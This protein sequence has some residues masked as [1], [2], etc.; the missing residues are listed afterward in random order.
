M[1]APLSPAEGTAAVAVDVLVA[2]QAAAAAQIT[3]RTLVL[4]AVLWEAI[5]DHRDPEQLGRFASRAASAIHAAESTTGRL[6]EAYLRRILR[7]LG[8]NVPARRRLVTMPQSL[9]YGVPLEDVVLRP[10][11]TVRFLRSEDTPPD[12]AG[13]AGRARLETIGQTQVQLAQR[14]AARQI[15]SSLD[16]VRAFRRVIRPEL[17]EGG[18][19]GLCIAASDRVYSRGDLLPIHDKCKC[20]TLPIVGE[21]DPGQRLNDEDLRRLYAAAGGTAGAK[22]KQVRYRIEQHGELG[23]VL[24]PQ[25]RAFRTA[26]QAGDDVLLG[27]GARTTR[28]AGERA[29]AQRAQLTTLEASIASLEQRAARGEDV[30]APL[31][32]QRARVDELRRSVRGR[33]A[34]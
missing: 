19:C 18:T 29:A 21:R 4:L 34:A 20:A 6:T 5:T 27:T 15:F 10:A 22:L 2:Q 7:S 1:T 8:V 23:P 3:D 16:R 25:G 13:A 30:T 33:V 14:E 12:A 26:D 32:W 17:S 9:R 11:A 31:E 28:P 24:V